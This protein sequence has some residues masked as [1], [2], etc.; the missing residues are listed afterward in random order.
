MSYELPWNPDDKY[1]GLFMF[2]FLGT[3]SACLQAFENYYQ[4]PTVTDIWLLFSVL[5]YANTLKIENTMYKLK[6]NGLDD[7]NHALYDRCWWSN[8]NIDSREKAMFSLDPD[9]SLVYQLGPAKP[10][11]DACTAHSFQQER[12]LLLSYWFLLCRALSTCVSWAP[13]A[14]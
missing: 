14:D 6:I 13:C 4:E 8:V 12:Y 1:C 3:A 10:L 5:H 7:Q 9:T 11:M 2:P